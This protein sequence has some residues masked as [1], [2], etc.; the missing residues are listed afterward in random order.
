MLNLK[1]YCLFSSFILFSY[2]IHGQ[3]FNRVNDEVGFTVLNGNSL[4]GSGVSFFDVNEDGWDDITICIGG[5]PT[6][7]Y[8]N[9]QGVFELTAYFPNDRDSKACVWADYDEDGDNDLIVLRR[10]ETSQ[11]FRNDNGLFQDISEDLNLIYTPTMWSWGLAAGDLDRNGFLDVY[12]A[13]YGY[14]QAKNALLRNNGNGTFWNDITTNLIEYV[15]TSFQPAWIDLNYDLWPDLYVINDRAQRNDY[16]EQISPGVFQDKSVLSGLGISIDAMSNSMSDYD[17]DGDFD[18]YITNING[19]RLLKNSN[20]TFTNVAPTLGVELFQWSWSGLWIDLE[21]N[22]WSDL[23]VATEHLA[24]QYPQH[25]SLFKNSQ[26]GLDMSSDDELTVLPYGGY[27]SAKGDLNNDGL[28]DIL[29]GAEN[30][31]FFNLFQNSSITSNQSFKFRLEG[32]C[33]NRNGFGTRYEIFAGGQKYMGYTQSSDNYISQNSQNI[34]Q[35]IGNVSK[36]DSINLYWTS[37]IVDHY[38]ELESDSLYVLVE[39]YGKDRILASNEEVCTPEDSV[40]LSISNWPVVQWFDGDT[41]HVKWVVGAGDYS[42]QIGT[43]FGKLILVN[44]EVSLSAPPQIATQV[45]LPLCAGQNSGAL[46]IYNEIDG[47]LLFSEHSLL[48]GTHTYTISYGN[49]CLYSDTVQIIDPSVLEWNIISESV[50]CNSNSN[51]SITIN[52]TGGVEPYYMDQNEISNGS[53]VFDGLGPGNYALQLHDSHGCLLDTLIQIVEPAPFVVLPN[54]PAA[55]CLN[56][57]IQIVWQIDGGTPPYTLNNSEG[58][59]GV[60]EYI[61]NFTDVNACEV[62]TNVQI[63]PLPPVQW[64]STVTEPT[65]LNNGE[66][67]LNVLNCSNCNVIWNTGDTTELLVGLSEGSYSFTIIDNWGCST[68]GQ[69]EL[70]FNGI[71]QIENQSIHWIYENNGFLNLGKETQHQVMCF[72]SSGKLVGQ[73]NQVGPMEYFSISNLANGIYFIL[74]HESNWKVPV[75]DLK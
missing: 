31:Q 62:Q 61:F 1:G 55:I 12:V 54:Y 24:A 71:N 21:N 34:I 41:S 75:Y 16:Y 72:D 14:P 52:V 5:A 19:N 35:G 47:S 67:Q 53:F 64:T 29:L 40:L 45:T 66:I 46:D 48:A 73:A 26:G 27:S 50:L 59:F 60:G 22:G 38:E 36:I 70:F 32:R 30:N 42:A 10:D 57:S 63:L 6:R 18:F 58:Y 74:T 11:Y 33:S 3:Y 37:G 44:H 49:G 28:Y 23:F 17:L 15:K 51:G 9:N 43:G 7:Y 13:N 56:D 8:Q 20:M 39:A 25:H 65:S 4:W 2:S 69:I 68:T